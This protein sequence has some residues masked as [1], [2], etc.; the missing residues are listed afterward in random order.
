MF[1]APCFYRSDYRFFAGSVLLA[2]QPVL[3][4][5]SSREK[6]ANDGNCLKSLRETKRKRMR[7]DG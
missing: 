7:K 5:A 6:T 2:L 4:P 1:I 3:W